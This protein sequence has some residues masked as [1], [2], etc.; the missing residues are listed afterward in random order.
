MR[1]T[2]DW[3][4]FSQITASGLISLL[5]LYSMSSGLATNQLI[6]WIIGL[7][8][9]Y[10]VAHLDYHIWQ[11]F[12]KVFYIVSILLLFILMVTGDPIRGSVRWIDLGFF[13]IQPSELAKASTILALA[14]FF[15]ERSARE[16][17]NVL[18]SLLLILPP[19]ILVFIQPDIGSSLTFLAIWFAVV[20][21][22]GFKLKHIILL[23]LISV[24]FIASFY[25]VLAPYQKQRITTFISP[26][27]DPLGT[28]YNI[29]QSKIAIGSG[30]LFGKGFG[31]GS[32]SQL[33]FLPEAESDFM[34]ASIS[35]QLGLVGSGFLVT[36]FAW[37]IS[38]IISIARE[39]KRYEQL[40]IIGISALL[41]AQFTINVGMNLALLPVTGIPFPLVS[42]G[43]SSL[44]T[45]LFLLGLV[46]AINRS[47]S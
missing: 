45:T 38:R 29:I 39:K 36:I 13:K 25:E 5:I 44:I 10:I 26:Q 2:W 19:F 3:L 27:R 22:S 17:N 21:I 11:S 46:F 12:S 14:S 4:L 34:F 24:I 43:G 16:I 41:I 28:G 40:L 6:Y 33:Q 7:C 15:R 20:I 1:K 42:Y 47:R 31:K 9:F 8:M 18:L 37:L 23:I 32:Q 35:E 30:N